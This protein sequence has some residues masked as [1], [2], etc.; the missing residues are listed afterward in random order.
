MPGP[1][2]AD[3]WGD[4]KIPGSETGRLLPHSLLAGVHQIIKVNP[5]AVT[6]DP[7][8]YQA[9]PVEP[10]P[11]LLVALPQF[12][13]HRLAVQRHGHPTAP[14]GGVLQRPVMRLAVRIDARPLVSRGVA[15]PATVEPIG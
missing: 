4:E 1:P 9:K 12:Q 11:G 14:V 5:L 10:P 6:V 7:G 8:R 15:L 3:K 2:P 13:F